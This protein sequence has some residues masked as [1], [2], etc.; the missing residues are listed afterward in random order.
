MWTKY[1]FSFWKY[2]LGSVSLR[3]HKKLIHA[4]LQSNSADKQLPTFPIQVCLDLEHP[5]YMARI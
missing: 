1:Y 2:F 4:S 5:T 3:T